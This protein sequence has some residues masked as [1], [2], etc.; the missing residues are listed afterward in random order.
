M[1][2]N[3]NKNK[4]NTTCYPEYDIRF[5]YSFFLIASAFVIARSLEGE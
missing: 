5:I 2:N 4:K 3:K 1:L